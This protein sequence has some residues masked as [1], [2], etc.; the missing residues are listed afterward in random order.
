MGVIMVL[1]AVKLTVAH[2]FFRLLFNLTVKRKGWILCKFQTLKWAKCA[3]QTFLHYNNFLSL[4]ISSFLFI[5]LSNETLCQFSSCVHSYK[6]AFHIKFVE[7]LWEFTLNVFPFSQWKKIK[8]KKWNENMRIGWRLW[9]Y[10]WF[11]S[12]MRRTTMFIKYSK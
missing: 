11:K 7:M 6:M 4:S 1:D 2:I 8:Q 5:L 10:C 3:N 9:K 12:S